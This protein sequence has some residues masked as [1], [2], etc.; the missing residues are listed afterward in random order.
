MAN[1]VHVSN[2]SKFNDL[3]GLVKHHA[4]F[5][6]TK[7]WALVKA[8]EDLNNK[9]LCLSGEIEVTAKTECYAASLHNV[10]LDCCNAYLSAD[11]VAEL[12]NINRTNVLHMEV[13]QAS[14]LEPHEEAA[15]WALWERL[16]AQSEQDQKME[17]HR[18]EY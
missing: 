12:I 5:V 11:F 2:A 13:A 7:F 17:M 1:L 6:N 9:L 18:N 14:M 3:L 15:Q 10:L 4:S 8:D 16:D